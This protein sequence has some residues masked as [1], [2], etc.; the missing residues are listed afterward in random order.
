MMNAESGRLVGKL[1]CDPGKEW[2]YRL[3]YT[4]ILGAIFT[5]IIQALRIIL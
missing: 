4:G 1:P 5:V 3:L 2:K